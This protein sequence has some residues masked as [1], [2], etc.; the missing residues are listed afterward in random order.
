[1]D[2]IGNLIDVETFC[3]FTTP[4]GLGFELRVTSN[5]IT[6]PRTK[7]SSFSVIMSKSMDMYE[8]FFW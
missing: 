8:K 7:A 6:F 2:L 1:M 4:P 5:F 3:N